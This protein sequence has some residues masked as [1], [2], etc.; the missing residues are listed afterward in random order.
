MEREQFADET[1]YAMNLAQQQ[2]EE[3]L[4][5]AR[6]LAK[7]HAYKDPVPCGEC[8]YCGSEV[9]SG[10]SFCKPVRLKIDEIDT[11][12][13]RASSEDIKRGYAIVD[14]CRIAY[15]QELEKKRIQ[16]EIGAHLDMGSR[17]ED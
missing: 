3:A 8:H 9:N 15:K 4:A 10:E 11:D 13:Y 16:R 7:E 2:T 17:S 1:E 12:L 5:N 14:E 6:A